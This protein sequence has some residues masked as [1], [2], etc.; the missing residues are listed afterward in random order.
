[1]LLASL[2]TGFSERIAANPAVPA[3][4]RE[5]I[6]AK[7]E[8]GIDIVPVDDVEQAAIEGGLS[9]EQATAVAGDYGDAQL[10][11]LRLGARRGC[12]VG[13][14]VAGGHAEAA[15]AFPR[16]QHRRTRG[17]PGPGLG[18]AWTGFDFTENEPRGG[19]DRGQDG[20]AELTGEGLD[21]SDLGADQDAARAARSRPPRAPPAGRADPARAG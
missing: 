14:A 21:R 17:G 18:S 2:A 8:E 20:R 16:R 12:A 11:A 7:A 9:Q 6:A 4:A 19:R 5:T 10:E 13:A 1:M 15:D 3:D